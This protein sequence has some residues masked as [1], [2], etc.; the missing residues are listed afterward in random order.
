MRLKDK[1]AIVTGAGAGI[2]EAIAHKFAREGAAVVVAD[3]P[4]SDAAE[5][6]ADIVKAGGRAEAYLGDLADEEAAR[7]CI[8]AAVD[9][10]GRLD[11]L[12]S[13][14]GMLGEVGEVDACPTDAFDHIMRNNTRS[15]FLMTK[16]AIP[17][18][19]A[20][21]GNIVFSGSITAIVGA[22]ELAAYAGSKGFIHAFMMAVAMEQA[23]HGVRVN[24]VAPGAIATSMTT[25][26]KGSPISKELEQA[27]SD[28]AALGRRGTPE[29]MANVA[30]F[31]ASDEASYVTGAIFV[32]DGGVVPAQ[33][34]PGQQVP[35]A[36][37]V[38]PEP[39]LPLRH[40]LSGGKMLA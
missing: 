25:S 34:A 3:I 8:A 35:A 20:S 23:K 18:L 14:A 31:L 39:T 1:V 12:A 37:K 38:A 10:F 16:F 22:G 28:G 36:L 32:A 6:A 17:H 29:E 30:L 11:V 5:I 15:A 27:T 40:A 9:R 21:R 4:K 7:A 19:Q 13:N 26:G 2:G 33:G 24:A